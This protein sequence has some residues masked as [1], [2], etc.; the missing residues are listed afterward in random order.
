MSSSVLL[1]IV[2]N[3]DLVTNL[4]KL[5]D[6]KVGDDIKLR[7][8][9]LHPHGREDWLSFYDKRCKKICECAPYLHID[10][11]TFLFKDITA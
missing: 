10:K 4:D 2:S 11:C 6:Y 3:I 9:A 5:T 8:Q 1:N 7:G